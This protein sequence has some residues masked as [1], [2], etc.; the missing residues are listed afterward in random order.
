MG[1]DIIFSD[2][3]DVARDTIEKWKKEKD[4]RQVWARG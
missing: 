1:V 2:R 4:L 3:P